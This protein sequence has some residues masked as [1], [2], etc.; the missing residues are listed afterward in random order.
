VPLVTRMRSFNAQLLGSHLLVALLTSIS[1]LLLIFV[2]AVIRPERFTL[3]QLRNETEHTVADWQRG[4]AAEGAGSRP[5]PG[6][7][8]FVV[9]VTADGVVSYRRGT[10]PC[11]VGMALAA[12]APALI[13]QPNG[14]RYRAIDGQR[15]AEVVL[16]LLDGAR[17]IGQTVPV[18][19][20]D[21][22]VQFDLG[23][24]QV[25]GLGPSLLAIG[26]LTALV[27]IPPALLL[28]WLIAGP[29]AR[30]LRAITRTS[31]RFANGD[32][33]A[34]IGDRHGDE[35]GMLAQQFDDMAGTLT[36][37]ITTLRDLA[38]QNSELARQVETTAIQAERLRLARDLH[39]DIAQQL[40]SLSAQAAA[41]LEQFGRDPS[42]GATQAQ[43]VAT[44]ADQ[45][46]LDLRAILVDLR[47]SQVR[48]RGLAEAL[49]ELC[50]RWQTA[51]GIP[52]E[53]AMVLDGR[54]LP[55]GV[56]DGIYRV[57]QESLSNVA[58]HAEAHAVF[59]SLVEG[60]RQIT[61]S[62]TDDGHGFDPAHAAGGGHF[63]LVSMQERARA[64]GGTLVIE[65]DTHQG[66]TV[67]LT[68]PLGWNE[69]GE[70]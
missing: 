56:A 45:T 43:A 7:D 60:Q 67:R 59:V 68:V 21:S 41:L 52:V 37:N 40:F 54:Y 19:L 55:S 26:L 51:H 6:Q 3:D 20:D 66:T 62:V 25:R 15:T 23:G 44:L 46:L 33:D 31:Q 1:L 69:D 5:M 34:R 2:L 48:Q 14:E 18:W 61:L 10:T 32:L 70:S 65:R 24:A 8:S 11:Q 42:L 22:T 47:P 53:T 63:G 50:Q 16:P 58:K 9:I 4:A 17:A 27:A 13:E 39:D 38:Q 64:L 12:C 29:L 49:Q 36:Q 35:V 28:T 57:A 30:R